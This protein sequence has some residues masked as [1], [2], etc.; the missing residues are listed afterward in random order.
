MT[1]NAGFKSAAFLLLTLAVVGRAS[2][3][4]PASTTGTAIGCAPTASHDLRVYL[5]NEAGALDQ[6]LNAA[7]AEAGAIWASAGVRLVWISPPVPLDEPDGRTAVVIIRRGL[8]RP[9]KADPADAHAGSHPSIGWVRFGDDGRPGHIEVSFELLTSLVMSGSHL[10]KPIS[11]LPSLAPGLLGLGL[12]RVVA[13]EI[14]H[15][16]MGRG[17]TRGGLMRPRF[18]LYD[19]IGS[20]VPRLPRTWT[21]ATASQRL[22]LY[23]GCELDASHPSTLTQESANSR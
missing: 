4:P 15:W 22:A 11:A 5:V 6:T 19:L 13:H 17:H 23:S 10:S 12:G 16:L 18:N 2:A 20:N 3:W 9:A 1:G 7:K 21:A 8:S 14:G